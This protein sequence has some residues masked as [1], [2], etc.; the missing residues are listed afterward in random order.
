MRFGKLIVENR[1]MI[2]T[3]M[4][5]SPSGKAIAFENGTHIGMVIDN[6]TVFGLTKDKIETIYKKHNEPMGIEGYA[7][8]EIIRGLVSKGWIRLRRYKNYW[9]VTVGSVNKRVKDV[10]YDWANKI[11][12]GTNGM[13]EKDKYMPVKIVTMTSPF[14]KEFTVDQIAHDKL[15]ESGEIRDKDVKFVI[16]ENSS[17]L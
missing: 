17:Q 9:S 15:Y 11:I 3:A 4:W 5:I 8:E 16:V 7:R 10:L 1:T 2:N 12:S 13:I 14:N 6:P